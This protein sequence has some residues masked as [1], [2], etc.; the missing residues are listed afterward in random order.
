MILFYVWAKNRK[1]FKRKGKSREKF[2]KQLE[3]RMRMA[4]WNANF[5]GIK[6]KLDNSARGSFERRSQRNSLSRKT[7]F[8][9]Q[10]IFSRKL[11]SQ[12]KRKRELIACE[13][14]I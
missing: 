11:S 7:C 9:L 5:F 13:I 8:L 10:R 12:L 1:D 6:S 4:N 2:K 3:T 14:A